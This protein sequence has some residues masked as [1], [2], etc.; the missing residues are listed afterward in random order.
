M[1]TLTVI[2]ILAALILAIAAAAGKWGPLALPVAVV[3]LAIVA[4]LQYLPV[5]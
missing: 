4:A 3:L 2:M 5:K 1:L